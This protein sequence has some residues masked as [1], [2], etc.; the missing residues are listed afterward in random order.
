MDQ[1]IDVSDIASAGNDFYELS[2]S[3]V[4]QEDITPPVISLAPPIKTSRRSKSEKHP[5][6]DK[7]YICNKCESSFSNASNLKSHLRIHTGEKPYA[8]DL[9]GIRF[10]Q[11]SNLK[12]HKRT[13]TGE[14]PFKCPDCGKA[15][16]RS[17]HLV[18]HKRIHTG[19]LPYSCGVCSK[20]FSSSTQLRKH[21]EKHNQSDSHVC[22]KC[23]KT[24]NKKSALAL[25][26]SIHSEKRPYICVLCSA[27][28]RSREDLNVHKKLHPG[29]EY[30]YSCKVCGK[31]FKIKLCCEKHAEKCASQF[32][33]K[34]VK[35]EKDDL[36]V[37]WDSINNYDLNVDQLESSQGNSQS[38]IFQFD[39]SQGG[40]GICKMEMLEGS[41][42]DGIDFEVDEQML[43]L[44]NEGDNS[45]LQ[46]IPSDYSVSGFT[47]GIQQC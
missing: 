45:V 30:P 31:G 16:S 40:H 42:E 36:E 46:V 34:S 22:S 37:L 2:F 41:I 25:H 39:D 33:K 4:C 29:N 3:P 23:D 18:G 43:V 27:A 19:E 17:S 1:L 28:F 21:V 47:T 15:F 14:R 24:F 35:L 10:V 9:C 12:A 5:S 20:S 11:S 38:Q 13:H 26:E 8:C 6:S 32:Q 44:T 7:F